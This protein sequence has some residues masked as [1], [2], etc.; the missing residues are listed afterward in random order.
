MVRN[1]RHKD[2]VNAWR[3]LHMQYAPVTSAT[4]QGFMKKSLEIPGAQTTSD[5]SSA[6]HILEELEKV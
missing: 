2:G 5:V 3:R 1:G 4:A 6:V